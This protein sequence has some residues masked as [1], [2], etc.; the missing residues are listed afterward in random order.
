MTELPVGRELSASEAAQ[1]AFVEQ[2]RARYP[3]VADAWLHVSDDGDRL[4]LTQGEHGPVLAE[5]WLD[6]VRD[7][8]EEG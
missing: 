6:V 5:L 7:A 4:W 2:C 3:D 8:L 1:R